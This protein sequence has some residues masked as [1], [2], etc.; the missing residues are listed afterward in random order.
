MAETDPTNGNFRPGSVL[1][2][3]VVMPSIFTAVGE[4]A[5]Q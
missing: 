3:V 1:P 5:T 4:T 2:A